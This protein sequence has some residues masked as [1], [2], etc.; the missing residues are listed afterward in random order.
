MS[1]EGLRIAR[2]IM[3]QPALE[4]FVQ[5]ERLPGPELATDEDLFEYGCANAKTDHHPVGT[6][7][8]GTDRMSVV[9]LDLKVRGIEGLRICDSSVMPRIPSC[10]TN[11]PT[12]MVG[13]KGADIIRGLD[14]LPAAIFAW[15]RNDTR[16]RARSEVC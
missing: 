2:E 10:N 9:D 6:C 3:R 13:E 16:A 4:P 7:K 12:I 14:P 11:G 1:L 5:A 8:M 15:E